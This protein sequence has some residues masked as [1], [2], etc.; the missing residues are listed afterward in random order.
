MLPEYTLSIDQQFAEDGEELGVF[1]IANTDNPAIQVKGIAFS[2]QVENL[3]FKD[4]LKYRIAAPV[5]MPGKVYRKN[6]ETGEESYYVVTPEFVEQA[7]VK[8]QATRAGKQVFN[9]EHDTN[10]KPPSFILETWFVTDPKNDKALH[11][12][13]IEVKPNT[14][15][16]VQQFT[17]KAVYHDYVERGLTGFSI[18]GRTAIA[19][20]FSE[21]K[22]EEETTN[23]NY[24]AMDKQIFELEGKQYYAD[25]N[26]V[27][28]PV[29]V[30][31]ET[32]MADDTKEKTEDTEMATETED[33]AKVEAKVIEEVKEEEK[34]EETEL[35]EEP[36]T[37]EVEATAETTETEDTEMAEEPAVE[38]Y[39]RAEIDAKFDELYEVIA[40]LKGERDEAEEEVGTEMSANT[41]MSEQKPWFVQKME[42]LSTMKSAKQIIADNHKKQSN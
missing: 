10:V 8:F 33:A 14:W 25:E 2:S 36:K 20:E 42:K 34:V 40:K 16:A 26:G 13:G 24:K 32:E 4:D 31:A 27:L 18:H 41:E 29:E 21:D 37:E 39:T 22:K 30:V 17:D 28:V 1:E 6:E 3:Y 11:Q 19:T 7:F 38:A 35:A 12:Y 5:L 15:F 9:E 23:V